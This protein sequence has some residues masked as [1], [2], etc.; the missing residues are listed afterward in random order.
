VSWYLECDGGIE[1][2]RGRDKLY[3]PTNYRR[4]QKMS[5]KNCGLSKTGMIN[6]WLGMTCST[7]EE[8]AFLMELT[9][10]NYYPSWDWGCC[11]FKACCCTIDP[12]RLH[13]KWTNIILIVLPPIHPRIGSPQLSQLPELTQTRHSIFGKEFGLNWRVPRKVRFVRDSNGCAVI[14]LASEF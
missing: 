5:E 4:K 3:S 8:F 2:E 12:V 9:F 14:C 13:P 11:F 1:E 6:D 7:Q 10:Q